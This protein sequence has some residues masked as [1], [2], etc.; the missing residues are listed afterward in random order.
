MMAGASSACGGRGGAARYFG[1]R[2]W[3]E[4]EP[5]SSVFPEET[6]LVDERRT[7]KEEEGEAKALSLP[8]R[9]PPLSL[10]LPSSSFFTSPFAKKDAAMPSIKTTRIKRVLAKKQKQNRPIPYWIRCVLAFGERDTTEERTAATLEASGVRAFRN[11]ASARAS[12]VAS[13]TRPLQV[14]VWRAARTE[15]R[16]REKRV[17]APALP[18]LFSSLLSLCCSFPLF[19]RA[20]PAR[21]ATHRRTCR[22]ADLVAA[23]PECAVG[24]VKRA[25]PHVPRAIETNQTARVFSAAAVRRRRCVP[26]SRSHCLLPQSQNKQKQNTQVPHGQQDPVQ[27]QAPPLAPHEAGHLNR[28]L[29]VGASTGEAEER[30]EAAADFFFGSWRDED[31]N[32]SLRASLYNLVVPRPLVPVV[33]GLLRE[34]TDGRSSS[35][36]S[37]TCKQFFWFLRFLSLRFTLGLGAERRGERRRRLGGGGGRGS[38]QN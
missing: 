19:S 30:Q 38:D 25:R 27:R 33:F 20:P 7:R 11:G 26:V 1:E 4:K 2:D 32:P 8:S 6:F 36:C 18:S 34:E 37:L 10:P 5:R 17:L 16:E 14:V 31:E 12:S 28:R 9:A 21:R 24:A 29:W 3:I 13:E 23:R 22:G 15:R 35:F